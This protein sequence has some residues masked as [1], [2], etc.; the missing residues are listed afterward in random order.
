MTFVLS[1][2]ERSTGICIPYTYKL[3]NTYWFTPSPLSAPHG[4][5]PCARDGI[6]GLGSR[7]DVHP[8]LSAT[9]HMVRV[10]IHIGL[11]RHV[12]SS[13]IVLLIMRGRSYGWIM[14]CDGGCE[15][16]S[17]EFLSGW[18][19]YACMHAAYL[20]HPFRVAY[21]PSI[22]WLKQKGSI[23]ILHHLIPWHLGLSRQRPIH[24]HGLQML[25]TSVQ[26][27]LLI[28]RHFSKRLRSLQTCDIWRFAWR[29]E[30]GRWSQ[31]FQASDRNKS[32]P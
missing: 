9:R 27:Q 7:S 19:K 26:Q 11:R 13:V 14:A 4:L 32:D 18:K 1:R 30:F 6:P 31:S 3:L 8:K 21:N 22:I 17:G 12:G 25:H 20:R 28:T 2:A 10:D 15:I 24:P 5:V 29:K 23:N 16:V